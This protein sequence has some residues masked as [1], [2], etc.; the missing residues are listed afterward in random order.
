MRFI[1]YLDVVESANAIQVF[2][3][4]RAAI[5]FVVA[6]SRQMVGESCQSA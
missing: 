1:I 5:F 4:R 3:K 6:T 2:C